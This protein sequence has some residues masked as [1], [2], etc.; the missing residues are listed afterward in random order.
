MEDV[1]ILIVEDSL[2]QGEKLKFILEGEGFNI[3]W[4]I[5]AEQALDFLGENTPTL[6]VTDVVLPRMDGFEL[7]AAIKKSDRWKHIPV[8]LLTTL[9]EPYDILR[10]LDSGADNFITKPYNRDYLISR[11]DYL[12]ANL[13]IRRTSGKEPPEIGIE[14]YFANKKHRITSARL[15]IIDLLFSTYDAIIQKNKELERLNRELKAANEEIKTLSGLI[16]ICSKCKK[17]RND[18]GY[19]QD[20]ED[21]VMAHT[22]A[23]FTHSICGD[24]LKK[25]YPNFY[26]RKTEKDKKQE[27]E[28]RGEAR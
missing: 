5:A 13:E 22:G 23:D 6:I 18:D 26:E 16:P 3:D 17:V 15:Q 24:C 14:I 7:C 19:W 10:G 27:K 25:L 9:S 12:L 20:V 11:I 2:T 1:S 4:V 8:I 28:A 21:Y